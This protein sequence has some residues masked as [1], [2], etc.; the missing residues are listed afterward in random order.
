MLISFF[1]GNAALSPFAA[2]KLLASIQAQ[3]P[4]V[5]MLAADY[6]HIVSFGSEADEAEIST[7][8]SLLHYGEA[9]ELSMKHK[10][11]LYVSPRPG[12]ISPWSSKATDIAHNCGL[13]C[14]ERIERAVVFT[15]GLKD[16][17]CL[18]KDEMIQLKALL[19]DRMTMSPGHYEQS[20]L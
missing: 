12:T 9:R 16:S 3:I 18:G 4:A 13:H 17:N 5:N 1:S 11:T 2:D 15:V 14:V 7:L 10:Q 8:E 19:H 20:I 6:L